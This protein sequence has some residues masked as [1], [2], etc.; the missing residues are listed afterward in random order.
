MALLN[1]FQRTIFFIILIFRIQ[2]KSFYTMSPMKWKNASPLSKI[3]HVIGK[4]NEKSFSKSH[5]QPCFLP[6]TYYIIEYVV[7]S[8]FQKVVN[9]FFRFHFFLCE[10]KEQI[11]KN[12]LKI[13]RENIL[14]FKLNPV[15]FNYFRYFSFN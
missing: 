4:L 2:L 15:S 11:D 14:I 10:K 8:F 5:N 7:P 6:Y 3:F 13:A 12:C 1:W 9:N